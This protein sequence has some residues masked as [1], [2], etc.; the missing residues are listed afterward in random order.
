MNAFLGEGWCFQRLKTLP[1]SVTAK[2]PNSEKMGIH[3]VCLGAH[4]CTNPRAPVPHSENLRAQRLSANHKAGRPRGGSPGS[5]QRSPAHS[6]TCTCV[7]VTD[8]CQTQQASEAAEL[9]TRRVPLVPLVDLFAGIFPPP[10]ELARR[11]QHEKTQMESGRQQQRMAVLH[12]SDIRSE[13]FHRRPHG[14]LQ[15]MHSS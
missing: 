12:R 11:D 15:G 8:L 10:R 13:R 1:K 4:V 9:S 6:P 5:P 3:G 7:S 14:R 2:Q